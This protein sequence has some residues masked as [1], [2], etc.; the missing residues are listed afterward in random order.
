VV[1]LPW[2]DVIIISLHNEQIKYHRVCV[3]APEAVINLAKIM[4]TIT[5]CR[6]SEIQFS[7][8]SS[9]G[10]ASTTESFMP[11]QWMATGD[12]DSK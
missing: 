4:R 2:I 6:I 10:N 3:C 9:D 8:C 7:S 5:T 12:R 11:L 1:C